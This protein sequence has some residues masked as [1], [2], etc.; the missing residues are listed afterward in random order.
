MDYE[1]IEN[2]LKK[3]HFL[4]EGWAHERR[5][6]Q[7]EKD[8]A[9]SKLRRVYDMMLFGEPDEQTIAEPAEELATSPSQ[10]NENCPEELTCDS[11]DSQE[12]D[13]Q[14]Q[15]NQ[16]PPESEPQQPKQV[17]QSPQPQRTLIGVDVLNSLYGDGDDDAFLASLECPVMP[18]SGENRS[19]EMPM[20]ENATSD[21]EKGSESAWAADATD[22]PRTES[23]AE[24]VE[25]DQI[26][27]SEESED[28]EEV[29]ESEESEELEEPEDPEESEALEDSE[30]ME[31]TEESQV[32]VDN[33]ES[34]VF[35]APQ[36]PVEPMQQSVPNVSF[37][38]DEVFAGVDDR[39]ASASTEHSQPVLGEVINPDCTVLGQTLNSDRH[40][41]DVASRASNERVDS[42]AGAVGLNDKFMLVDELFD[43]DTE[44]Y[45]RTV[46]QLDKFD[47]I[48]GA[49]IFLAENFA[50]NPDSRGARMISDLL[51]RR[52]L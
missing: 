19:A 47:S 52:F 16:E 39:V 17:R 30:N 23:R 26:E 3:V 14:S 8:L 27:L 20:P 35:D 29:E 2:E 12:S 7:L 33:D 9:L 46:A 25:E 6:D 5:V 38:L 21:A 40:G 51:A 43:G 41:D 49:L 11:A 1:K 15:Q 10:P 34:E 22:S 13:S 50:W 18:E 42:I 48:D 44:A 37:E 36:E 31:D 32:W 24:I 45:N 28:L 4:V